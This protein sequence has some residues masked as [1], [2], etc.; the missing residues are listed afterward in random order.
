MGWWTKKCEHDFEPV[1]YESVTDFD[2]LSQLQREGYPIVVQRSVLRLSPSGEPIFNEYLYDL[3]MPGKRYEGSMFRM[4]SIKVCL[5]CGGV[6]N[7][8]TKRIDY[9]CDK[10][11]KAQEAVTLRETEKQKR[12][13][14]A[15]ELWEAY[16]HDRN[17]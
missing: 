2:I 12:R 13:R 1:Q 3:E 9:W 14:K 17:K 10:I 15:K 16:N 6:D 8:V 5:N 11:C 7:E 4:Y